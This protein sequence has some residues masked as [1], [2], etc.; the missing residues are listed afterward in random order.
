MATH[1]ITLWGVADLKPFP[2]PI[3]PDGNRF[4]RAVSFAI[5]MTPQIMDSIPEGPNQAYAEEYA[6]V[7]AH[8]NTLSN[9]LAAEIN[10]R[11][12][13]AQALAASVRSDPVNIKGDFPQKTAATR[14]GLGWIG[15]NCQLVNRPFGPW[16]RL[17]TVFTDLD[18]PCGPPTERSFC[19]RCTAC[20]E[21]C[22]ANALQGNTWHPG[23]PRRELLDVRACDQWKKE[24]YYQFHKGHNCGICSAVCPFGLKVLQRQSAE[25]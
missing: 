14:A 22:P 18:L 5:P 13:R 25:Q 6:R 16:V 4:P 1:S 11:G 9:E 17:G 10:R 24:H 23:L 3:D 20:I 7:N 15:K 19:G 12:A 21:A 2:T 8:I